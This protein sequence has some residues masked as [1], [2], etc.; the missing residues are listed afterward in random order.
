[1]TGMFLWEEGRRVATR[2]CDP[3]CCKGQQHTNKKQQRTKEPMSGTEIPE[4]WGVLGISLFSLWS[5]HRTLG[6]Q[7]L[8]LYMADGTID[9]VHVF[10]QTLE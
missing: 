5:Q 3:G 2:G 9:W 8:V 10:V 1:M 6:R 7:S 4:S